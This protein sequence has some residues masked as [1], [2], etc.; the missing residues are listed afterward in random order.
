MKWKPDPRT[1]MWV[2]GGLI[3]LLVLLDV[4]LVWRVVGGPVNGTTFVCALLVLLSL[5]TIALIGYRVY[6]LSQLR[7]EFDRNHLIIHTAGTRQIVPT[8]QIERVI[9]GRQGGLKVRMRSLPWPGLFLGQGT[10]EGVGLTLFYAV[11]PPREQAIVVTPAL[12]YGI[13]VDDMDSFLDVLT[14]CQELGPSVEVR[15]E[16]EQSLYVRWDIWGD[17]LA[18]GVLLG[19]ILLNVALFGMLLFRYPRLPNLLPLHYDTT[20][21]V[22]RI[23]PREDVFAL[24]LIALITLAANGLLG[25]L[26]YRRE[27]VV[28]YMV[29]GGGV[30]VQVVFLLALWTIVR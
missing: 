30:L 25:A 14:T 8:C 20:G 15:Q 11:T 4:G 16:S 28:S 24:P 10:V 6:D 27:R 29:W 5:P 1:G 2:G 22:D 9:D 18:Q 12:A 7:Y 26:L 21:A 17:R 13:S 3:V 23:S 19:G